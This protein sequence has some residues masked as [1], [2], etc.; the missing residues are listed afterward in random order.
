MTGST[1]GAGVS[2]VKSPVKVPPVTARRLDISGVALSTYC[3]VAA[4]KLEVGSLA[5]V[6]VPVIVPPVFARRSELSM[7]A[8]CAAT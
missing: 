5:S 3:L 2:I 8:I 1:A 4:S 7:V 6:S